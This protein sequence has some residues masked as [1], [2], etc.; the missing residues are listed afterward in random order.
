MRSFGDKLKPARRARGSA[1]VLMLLLVALGGIALVG[2]AR[3]DSSVVRAQ[4]DDQLLWV[5][6]EFGAAVLSY[7]HASPT[8]SDRLPRR[9]EDLIAD[10][11]SGVLR[12]HL[13]RVFPNPH[14]PGSAW[15]W[16]IDAGT[17]SLEIQGKC[18][19]GSIASIQLWPSES[20][21]RVRIGNRV[22]HDGTS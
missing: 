6:R 17:Q 4:R 22:T 18:A 12:R 8:G 5:L 10:R 1:Y 11:R 7:Y 21:S 13:R 16:H 14:A 3:I 19:D 9:F 2:Y 20:R 15:Q